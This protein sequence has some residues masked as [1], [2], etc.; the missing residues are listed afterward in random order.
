MTGA[1]PQADCAPRASIIVLTYNSR[2]WLGPL[3][4]SLSSTVGNYEVIVADNASSDGSAEFVEERYPQARV[5]RNGGNL[6]YAAGNNRAAEHARGDFLVFLNPDT[7]VEPEWLDR[8]LAPFEDPGVGA[9]AAK[10]LLMQEPGTVNS[11]GMDVHISG[12]TLCRGMG[13]PAGQF[14][15]GGEVAAVAGAAFAI[16]RPLFGELRG[17]NESFFMYMED[18]ALSLEVWLRG[19]RCVFVPDS[20]VYHDYAL[21]FGPRKVFYQE[22][23]RY[24]TLLQTYRIPTLI[25]LFPTLLLAELVTWGFVVARDRPNWRNKLAAYS[26]ILHNWQAMRKR[27]RLNQSGRRVGDRSILGRICWTLD[28]SQVEATPA[29]KMAALVFDPLFRLTRWLTLATVRW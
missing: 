10:V 1:T 17:F 24:L 2:Q 25:V 22:R 5:V 18:T 16:R 13:R 14:L 9:A 12:L 27:R 19:W 7:R 29:A 6:G 4:A 23:N 11:C 21:R 26:A 3:M 8:L 15:A 20:V 28:F